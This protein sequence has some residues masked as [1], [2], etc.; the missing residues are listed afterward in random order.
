MNIYK[1][2][3]ILITGASSGI[4]ECFAET[5]DKM[6]AKLILT[7]RSEDKLNDMA[8]KMN[9]V[10]V[11]PGDLSDKEYPEKLHAEIKE[12]NIIN[13]DERITNKRV[14]NPIFQKFKSC[15]YFGNL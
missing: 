2:K 6:G 4:G 3:T 15:R 1:D 9:N 12:K 14:L 10:M 5:L 8:A 7:A 13:A 11:I